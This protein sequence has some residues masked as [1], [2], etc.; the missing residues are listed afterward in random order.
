[1][2][3]A[4]LPCFTRIERAIDA[5]ARADQRCVG[6]PRGAMRLPQGGDEH[7]RLGRRDG[8]IGDADIRA[9]VERSPPIRPAIRRLINSTLW[10]GPVGVTQGADVGDVG[11]RGVERN[12]A[13]LPGVGQAREAPR[14]AAIHGFIDTCT[15]G[16][17]RTNVAF[18][19]ADVNDLRVCVGYR[20]CANGGHGLMVENRRPDRSRVDGL[21]H[22]AVDRAKVEGA[23]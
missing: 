19:G 12:F 10:V 23:P 15:G 9:F 13:D 6:A 20:E 22:A 7:A 11:V 5:A 17:I 2:A 18:P 21:P 1:M 16:E 14:V 4:L 8:K 3:D